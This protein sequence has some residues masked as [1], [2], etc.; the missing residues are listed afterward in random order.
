M[1][2]RI[3]SATGR[4]GREHGLGVDGERHLLHVASR[5]YKIHTLLRSA[6]EPMKDRR[7]R[8]VVLKTA[9]EKQLRTRSRSHVAIRGAS[10]RLPCT[11]RKG[12]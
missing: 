5:R 3:D 2:K 4:L 6:D 10:S 8:R 9:C 11:A 1:T 7:K 12:H